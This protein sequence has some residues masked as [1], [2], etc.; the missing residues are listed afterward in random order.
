MG[1]KVTDGKPAL[2]GRR[3]HDDCR[4]RSSEVTSAF[5]SVTR[6]VSHAPQSEL[7]EPDEVRLDDDVAISDD[8]VR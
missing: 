3:F 8:I 4:F 1:G 2:D 6:A 5:C 7:A